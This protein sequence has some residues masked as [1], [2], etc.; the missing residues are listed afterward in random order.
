VIHEV[1]LPIIEEHEDDIINALNENP[2][3]KKKVEEKIERIMKKRKL[4]HGQ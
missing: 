2:E 1:F 4:K 3:L